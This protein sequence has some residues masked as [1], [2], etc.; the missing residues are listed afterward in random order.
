MVSMRIDQGFQFAEEKLASVAIFHKNHKNY[1]V[2][3]STSSQPARPSHNVPNRTPKDNLLPTSRPK[4][5][6]Q[7]FAFVLHVRV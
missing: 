3:R 2:V 4:N 6:L 7:G 1:P 5:D